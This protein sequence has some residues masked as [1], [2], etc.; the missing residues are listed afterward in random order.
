MKTSKEESQSI[1]N[2]V[3]IRVNSWT[4]L[5]NVAN[6]VI[7][8]VITLSEKVMLR[9][10]IQF[11][12]R[13]ASLV[14]LS[15]T[16]LFFDVQKESFPQYHENH[17]STSDKLTSLAPFLD[18]ENLIRVGGRLRHAE[19]HERYKYPI[20]LPGKHPVTQR[21]IEHH[22]RNVKHQGRVITT[23]RIRDEGFYVTS[24]SKVVKKIVHSCI[25]CR[26]LRAL[27][28]QQ[29]M[30]DLPLDRLHESPPFT[31]AGLDAFGPFP[32]S[33]GKSTRKSSADKKIWALIFICLVTKAVHIELLW[34][35]DINSFKH[36]LRRFF[37]I[38]GSCVKL[39]SDRGSN[40]VGAFNQEKVDLD[41]QV[42]QKE[43]N[44]GCQWEFNPPHSSN[45]GGIWERSIRSVRKVIDAS[46]MMLGQRHPTREELHTFLCEAA[47]IINNT[48]MYE[49]TTDPNDPLPITPAKLL[50]MKDNPNPPPLE[51]FSEH[52][53]LAYGRRR[54]RR[55][56]ALS[57]SFWHRWRSEYIQELQRRQKWTQKQQNLQPGDVVILKKDMARRNFW[58]LAIVDKVKVSKD[59]LVR[60]ATITLCSENGHKKALERPIKEM[61]LILQRSE[62]TGFE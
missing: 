21:L 52:D 15:E 44:Q 40:F 38:R 39:R 43:I 48:P 10:G 57:E 62:A 42:V 17:I 24:I 28:M 14:K 36:S 51:S 45:F 6:L 27:P 11:A 1:F 60:S 29:Q 53:I 41:M 20:L 31:Y 49:I 25:T 2:N 16:L 61:V 59:E 35:M 13:S 54:W 46:L 23:A 56:Q 18:H 33:E 7:K 5:V 19:S 47:C 30:S 34:H 37:S 4:K 22:H 9:R 26:K 8:F 58:P 50:T 3:A 55:M 12:S 32:V